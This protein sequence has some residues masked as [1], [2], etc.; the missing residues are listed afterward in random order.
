MRKTGRRW[1]LT[2]MEQLPQ[3]STFDKVGNGIC[4]LDSIIWLSPGISLT[5]WL[6]GMNAGLKIKRLR[7]SLAQLSY[8]FTVR[9]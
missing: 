6:H 9:P 1:G 5:R 4:L 8:L 7:V 3:N 2:L